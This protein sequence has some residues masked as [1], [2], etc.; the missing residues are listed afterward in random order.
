MNY[1]PYPVSGFTYRI[2]QVRGKNKNQE[3]D[4]V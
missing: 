3:G 2:E 4:R 1:S